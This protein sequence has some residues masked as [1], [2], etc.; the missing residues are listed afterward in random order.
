M[1]RSLYIV[2]I[3]LLVTAQVVAAAAVESNITYYVS[4]FMGPMSL[5]FIWSFVAVA[6][7]YL[8]YPL[9]V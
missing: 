8:P 4:I 7:R 3:C 9:W 2:Q 6:G 5:L 1:E